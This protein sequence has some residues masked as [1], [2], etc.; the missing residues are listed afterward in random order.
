MSIPAAPLPTLRDILHTLT[1]SP[2]SNDG[3]W[4]LD[5]QQTSVFGQGRS[6]LVVGIDALRRARNARSVRV[7]FPGYICEDA[8]GVL[9]GRPVDLA[10]YPVREDLV[11]DWDCVGGDGLDSVDLEVFVLVHYFGFPNDGTAA[12]SFCDRREMVLIEDGAHVAGPLAGMGEGDMTFYSPSKILAGPQGGVLAAAPSLVALPPTTSSAWI[13]GP[14]IRWLIVRLAQ[15]VCVR[16]GIPWHGLTGLEP[17]ESSLGSEHCDRFTLRML[18]VTS[19]HLAEAI[20][21]RRAN[22]RV[23]SEG[24]LG[25]VGARPFRA[26]LPDEVCPYVF[27][28]IV[29]DGSARMVQALKESGVPASEWPDLPSEVLARSQEHRVALDMY[30]RLMLLPV[31]QSLRPTDLQ[32]MVH[33]LRNVVAA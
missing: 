8:L 22:Y 27:P 25:I 3:P 2:Y 9:R 30:R 17:A 18:S 1:T 29:D 6:A 24:C 33:R 12:R 13:S 14:T 11:P 21:K 4:A 31:H 28:V 10:F 16:L 26:E 20:E 15:K 5:S 19:R 32:L 23:M 7:W